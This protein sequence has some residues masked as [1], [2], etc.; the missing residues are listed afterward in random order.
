MMVRSKFNKWPGDYCSHLKQGSVVTWVS[1]RSHVDSRFSNEWVTIP[2]AYIASN[3]LNYVL[4]TWAGDVISS[5]RPCFP[6][7]VHKLV[8]TWYIWSMRLALTVLCG[9]CLFNSDMFKPCASH[10]YG[11]FMIR[12]SLRR[13]V[14]NNICILLR[15]YMR[16]WR[17]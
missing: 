2:V 1:N 9:D 17:T 11:S 7:S 12:Q 8:Y 15:W 13:A 3:K 10:R 14:C 4:V 6:R 16:H 5:F